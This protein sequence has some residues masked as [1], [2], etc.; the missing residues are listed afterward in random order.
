[1][2]FKYTA[3]DSTGKET[4]GITHSHSATG[5]IARIRAR[6]LFPTK[7][8]Q[9]GGRTAAPVRTPKFV[10]DN[11][12]E[13]RM[14]IVARVSSGEKALFS[15][16]L[17][18]MVDSGLPLLRCLRIMQKNERNRSLRAA[19]FN[20]GIAIESGNTF[21]EALSQYPKVFDSVFVNM[22]R[23]GE[24]GGVLEVVLER[25]ASYL[26]RGAQI[27]SSIRCALI[28]LMGTFAMASIVAMLLL[29]FTSSVSFGTVLASA[30]VVLVPVAIMIWLFSICCRRMWDKV[31]LRIPVFGKLAHDMAV[32]SWSRM[33]G[34]LL[35]SGVPV[36]QAIMI[37]KGTCS[38]TAFADMSQSVHDA[39]KEGDS[40][41][42]PLESAKVFPAVAV[43]MVEVGEETGALPDM[44]HR[45]SDL[46]EGEVER[47]I[48]SINVA[49]LTVI[50]MSVVAI[51]V[52]LFANL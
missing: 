26:E 15:R 16:K 30:A 17:A 31:K 51:A 19:S 13:V 46:Y 24:A 10:P 49:S 47:R 43:G 40:M 4:S 8:E 22:V 32:A 7:V 23:A 9:V 48:Q 33:L 14:P 5:A 11:Y 36:L 28:G 34:L 44:L 45:V 12:G 41:T 1:M 38:N 21:S 2:E 20:M 27:R 52:V 37:T 18:T 39:I 6:S 35:G 42:S 25:L 29:S 3:I 50:A